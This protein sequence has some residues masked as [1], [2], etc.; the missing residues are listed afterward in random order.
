[1]ANWSGSPEDASI[2]QDWQEQERDIE[3]GFITRPGVF[4]ADGPD[5]ASVALLSVLPEKFGRAVADFG[6]GWGFLSRTIA[7]AAPDS[8]HL[9]EAD[10]DALD[11]AKRNIDA[12]FAQFHWDDATTWSSPELL[13][14][15]VMNPPFHTG[16]KADPGLGQA[17]IANAARNLKPSGQLWMVANRHLPYEDTLARNFGHIEDVGGD[18]RFKIFRASRPSRKKR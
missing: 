14:S 6:A 16:R 13:D 12:P 2:P 17:F 4:S 3:G 15:I 5:P 7:Q 11:C 8:L 10:L 9:V 1:M 18:A